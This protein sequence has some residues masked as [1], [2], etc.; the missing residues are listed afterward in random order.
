MQI[1]TYVLISRI[2]GHLS[3]L[4]MEE[5][6]QC[7]HYAKGTTTMMR[8]VQNI[9]THDCATRVCRSHEA[10]QRFNQ[11]IS[12]GRADKQPSVESKTNRANDVHA[13]GRGDGLQ[14]DLDDVEGY[15]EEIVRD[16]VV[17]DIDH[18]D[19]ARGRPE[20]TDARSKTGRSKHA[21]GDD[22]QHDEEWRAKRSWQRHN[23][24]DETHDDIAGKARRP[25][26]GTRNSGRG[27]A[28]QQVDDSLSEEDA[29]NGD[30]GKDGLWRVDRDASRRDKVQE[31][32]EI[33][34]RS[35]IRASLCVFLCGHVCVCVSV[36]KCACITCFHGWGG[37]EFCER[38][39]FI[40]SASNVFIRRCVCLASICSFRP[41]S[42]CQ[43]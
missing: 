7:L 25:A 31:E 1:F 24:S 12:A 17:L 5:S 26:L 22:F 43:A 2:I 10:A 39:F 38:M 14:Q 8:M 33:M 37:F 6:A 3:L 34:R 15:G 27:Y 21:H 29:S 18:V 19:R 42:R 9:K 36:C 28:L 41:F 11:H 23:D 16:G 40:F 35:V 4:I 32:S 20:E 13:A 30:Q